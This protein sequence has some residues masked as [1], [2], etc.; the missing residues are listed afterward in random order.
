[1][2]GLMGF[3]WPILAGSASWWFA[4]KC[5]GR[6][7]QKAFRYLAWG[8]WLILLHFVPFALVPIVGPIIDWV[9]LLKLLPAAFMFIAAG[10]SMLKEM[11]SQ[12][13]GEYTEKAL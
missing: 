10:N 12:Q 7:A 3:L 11:R 8:F 4:G 13:R 6:N 2:D 5:R 9:W 1:M